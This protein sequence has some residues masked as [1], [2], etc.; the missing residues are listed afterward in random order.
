MTGSMGGAALA[1]VLLASGLALGMPAQA[2]VGAP[3]VATGEATSQPAPANAGK[4]DNPTTLRAA[5]ELAGQH[6]GFAVIGAG[7]LGTDPPEW[8]AADLPAQ[9]VITAL[10]KD[11]SYIVVLKPETAPGA[12]RE[13]G[14]VVVVGLNHPSTDVAATAAP[15]VAAPKTPAQVA[16]LQ[17]AMAS[18]GAPAATSHTP[19]WA[20]PPSTVVRTLTKL[21]ETN[22][23]S[24]LG[25]GTDQ[26]SDSAQASTASTANPADSA[27]AM[28]A[29]T[30][31]AQS[32]LGALVTGLRQACPNPKAC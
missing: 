3:P 30:R 31:S 24:V 5:V 9:D 13:P 26:S 12:R 27:A 8:P 22:G 32:G 20:P 25:T 11:Y 23:N 29:L 7:R 21:A 2:A 16:A 15:A 6:F 4:A 28:A 10:L 18:P 14:T 1:A 17:P 19:S